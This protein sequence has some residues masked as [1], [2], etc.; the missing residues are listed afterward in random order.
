MNLYTV[1][2]DGWKAC[3]NCGTIIPPLHLI[4]DIAILINWQQLRI[5]ATY[6]KRWIGQFNTSIRGNRDMIQVLENILHQ[7][8][9]YQ[10]QNTLPIIDKEEIN[11]AVALAS[12]YFQ[13][14]KGDDMDPEGIKF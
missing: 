5:M 6:S 13:Q 14:P 2:K 1:Q 7:L 11:N 9:H 12:P 3:P 4:Y 8:S 10:P